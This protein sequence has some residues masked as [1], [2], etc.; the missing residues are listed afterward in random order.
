MPSPERISGNNFLSNDNTKEGIHVHSH[1]QDQRHVQCVYTCNILIKTVL[2]QCEDP[3]S[4][5]KTIEKQLA[6][7][8]AL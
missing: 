2:T 8:V 1:D 3:I 5:S 4:F 6:R 7:S